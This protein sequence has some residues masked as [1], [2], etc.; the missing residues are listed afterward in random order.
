ME[1]HFCQGKNKNKIYIYHYSQNNEIVSHY[2]DLVSKMYDL[3]S[4]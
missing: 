1:T 3:M 4:N 2:N